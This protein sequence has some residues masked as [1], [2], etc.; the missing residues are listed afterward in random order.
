MAG[1][2]SH[3]REWSG[4][5]VVSKALSVFPAVML[6]MSMSLSV[7]R[8]QQPSGDT[9]TPGYTTSAP[10]PSSYA[11]SSPPSDEPPKP[12]KPATPTEPVKIPSAAE[13]TS[14]TTWS[15]K[16]GGVAKAVGSSAVTAGK[17][18]DVGKS[19]E[20]Q[21]L[22]DEKKASSSPVLRTAYGLMSKNDNRGAIKVLSDAIKAGP[23]DPLPRR[24]L[25]LALIRDNRPEL[26]LAQEVAVTGLVKP[27]AF[28]C[29]IYGQAY[30]KAKSWK[31]AIEFLEDG[32][33]IRVRHITRQDLVQ[34]RGTW[35]PVTS[36]TR[37][38]FVRR[39]TTW[40]KTSG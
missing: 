38:L 13:V 33:L 25:A 28:D 20:E 23:T 4:K 22:D 14:A 3:V 10:T 30:L 18:D 34:L 7:A 21:F 12:I 19:P 39:A 17:S 29:Y 27:T 26:A 35:E 31:Q 36:L 32:D 16:P 11:T 40:L 9:P 8:A 37:C 5:M 6:A 24:Y 2:N 1:L 15:S